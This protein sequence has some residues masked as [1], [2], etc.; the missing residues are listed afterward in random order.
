[1]SQ[2]QIH[3]LS[4]GYSS[5][6]G[7]VPALEHISLDLADGTICTVAGPSGGGKS[8]LLHAI[9]GVLPH[10][11]GTILLD[12]VRPMPTQHQIALVP[13]N[14]GLMPW[15]TVADNIALPQS[16]GKRSVATA[17]RDEIV[18]RLGLEHLLN[19]YPHELSGGQRQ[20]VALAR[21]F[22]MQ[23]DL[24][25]MDEPFSA[26]D[27][28]TAERSRELFLQLWRRFPVTTLLVTHSPT[29]AAQ[30]GHRAIVIAGTPGRIVADL[31]EPSQDALHRYL[32]S[33]YDDED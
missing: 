22:G 15:K 30:L 31:Y 32:L 5:A 7:L 26:L 18:Q 2:L 19:R 24:L 9:A 10:Y 8:T 17:E 13:Q 21:A 16:L 6:E 27:I 23:P 12:G 29:E 1:M 25:L 14:Y 28:V 20:R 33:A 3:Q 4:I 11:E